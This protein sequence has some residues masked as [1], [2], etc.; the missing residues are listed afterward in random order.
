[1]IHPESIEVNVFSERGS[2][3]REIE[4]IT[5]IENWLTDVSEHTKEWTFTE[6]SLPPNRDKKVHIADETREYDNAKGETPQIT[7]LRRE[8][9]SFRGTTIHFL[10]L[11]LS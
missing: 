3:K 4:K 9:T 2:P 8:L 7:I 10:S 6:D 5:N 11:V 1:M